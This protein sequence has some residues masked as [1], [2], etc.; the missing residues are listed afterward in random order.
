[1]FEESN[2]QAINKEVSWR[3]C[4]GAGHSTAE[5]TVELVMVHLVQPFH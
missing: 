3:Q 5:E 2:I 4:N 1:M